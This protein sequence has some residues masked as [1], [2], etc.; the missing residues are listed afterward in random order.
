MSNIEA[1]QTINY[2]TKFGIKNV[3][4]GHLSNENNFPDLAYRSVLE[5]IENKDLN[6]LIANRSQ[7]TEFFNVG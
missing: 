3:M 4:L 5:Q 7:P 6:L 1:G 2:L